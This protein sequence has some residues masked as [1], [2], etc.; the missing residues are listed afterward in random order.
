[1]A[2]RKD[3]IKQQFAAAVEPM[4]EPGEELREG[5]YCQTGPNP[6]WLGAIGI[7][8]MLL[9]GLR[10]YFIGVTDRRILW[11][12]GSFWSARPKGLAWADPVGQPSITAVVSDAKLWNSFRYT[13][14]G[15]KKLRVNV[16]R[17]WR[18]ELR[19]ALDAMASPSQGSAAPPPPPMPPT[20]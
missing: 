20:P 15:G 13:R 1:M 16:H 17:F 5:F 3:K 7:G 2:I 8:V 11:V 14:S 19:R 9:F 10:Y 18:D 6:W 4:L 12:K